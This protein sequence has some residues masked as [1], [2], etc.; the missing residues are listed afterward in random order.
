MK[1]YFLENENPNKD[2]SGGIM[3]Y[4]INLSKV[5]IDKGCITILCGS[6]VNKGEVKLFSEFINISKKDNSSNLRYFILLFLKIK[7]L[8]I[9]RSSIIHAQRPD[10]LLP[11]I[12]FKSK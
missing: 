7:F 8:K 4:L 3:S 5:L 2:S 11:A 12:L 10:M 9:N 1:I 6:G